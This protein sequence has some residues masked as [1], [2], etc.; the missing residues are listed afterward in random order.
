MCPDELG[1][2]PLLSRPRETASPM[3]DTEPYQELHDPA[4]EEEIELLADVIEA[5]AEAGAAL[6]PDEIDH[7]LGLDRSVAVVRQMTRAHHSPLRSGSGPVLN[8]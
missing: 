8:A 1:N 7:A 3:A 2:V 6:R 4:L 5:A